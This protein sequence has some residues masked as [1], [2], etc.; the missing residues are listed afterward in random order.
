[1]E[2]EGQ[3]KRREDPNANEFREALKILEEES[4]VI[5]MGDKFKPRIKAGNYAQ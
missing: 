2:E 3:F 4:F 1:V 5:L